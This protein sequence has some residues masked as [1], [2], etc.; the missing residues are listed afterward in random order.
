MEVITEWIELLTLILRPE[1]EF[2]LS[3]EL[4]NIR[5]IYRSEKYFSW[6]VLEIYIYEDWGKYF[7]G[8]KIAK[9]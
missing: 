9:C 2:E 3:L 7:A 1:L 8:E 5:K 4:D 6:L